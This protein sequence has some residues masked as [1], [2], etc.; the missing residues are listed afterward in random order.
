MKISM[1]AEGTEKVK[2]LLKELGDKSEGVA[3]RGLYEGAGVIADRLKAAA[4][5]IK[6]EEFRGKRES[7]KPS[8]EEKAIVFDLSNPKKTTR[9]KAKPS[10]R[11]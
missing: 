2:A 3:K 4:E 8:P 10:E 5:T 11:A 9:S 6:T 7:R 1:K